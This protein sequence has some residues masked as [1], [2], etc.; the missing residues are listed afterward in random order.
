M[1]TINAKEHVIAV[2]TKG[3]GY[4][5]HPRYSMGDV[6]TDI[7]TGFNGVVMAISFHHTGAIHYD[8]SPMEIAKNNGQIEDPNWLNFDQSRL[9]KI[10]RHQPTQ[11]IIFDA[12][13][14]SSFNICL[15]SVVTTKTSNAEKGVVLGAVLYSSG[16]IR[17]VV[18][19]F[20]PIVWYSK[21]SQRRIWIDEE[22][23]QYAKQQKKRIKFYSHD[24]VLSSPPMDHIPKNTTSI[25]KG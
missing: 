18:H 16:C 10:D 1:L 24:Q 22:L 25:P 8:L 6:L 13:Y 15:G 20:N 11:P 2:E 4:D 14:P 23:L 9:E 21:V 19:F 17:Y 3:L 5:F 7:I 12:Q